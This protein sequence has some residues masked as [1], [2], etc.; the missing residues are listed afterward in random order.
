[1]EIPVPSISSLEED[2]QDT[3][4]LDPGLVTDELPQPYRMLDKVLNQTLDAVWDLITERQRIR[5]EEAKIIHPPLVEPAST[6][7]DFA[8]LST[9][10]HSGDGRYVFV[11]YESA[12]LVAYDAGSLDRITEWKND[13]MDICIEHMHTVVIG[14]NVHLLATIDDM[15]FAR[16]LLF[17][18]E[19][20]Y[21]ISLLNEQPE[22]GAKSNAS[23]FDLS[24]NGD[25]CGLVLE[26][27]RSM[28]ID[29]YKIPRDSWLREIESSQK[30]LLKKQQASET[31]LP[32]NSLES[33]SQVP[34]EAPEIKF[35]PISLVL[36]VKPPAQLF[37][38][39]FS[40]H[41]EAVE[42]AGIANTIGNGTSHLF[43]DDHLYKR[44]ALFKN[45]YKEELQGYNPD[46][47]KFTSPNWHY[48]YQARLQTEST[49]STSLVEDTPV[50]VCIW[51]KNHYLAQTY[52]LLSKPTKDVEL[53]PDLVWPMCGNISS[54]TVSDCTNII[55]F[56]LVNGF[57]TVID[58]HLCLPRATV[59]VGEQTPVA[60]INILNSSLFTSEITGNTPPIYCSLTLENGSV[61]LLDCTK[62][63]CSAVISSKDENIRNFYVQHLAEFP[64]V[65]LYSAPNGKT[66][67]YDAITGKI[68]CE[69]AVTESLEDPIRR[70]YLSADDSILYVKN[71]DES[72]QSFS[73]RD[74]AL[75]D[76]FHGE[77]N[78][79]PSFVV[80]ETIDERCQRFLTQRITQQRVRSEQLQASWDRMSKELTILLSMKKP[81]SAI[82][83][84]SS[85]LS[86]WH[87]AT[88]SIISHQQALS[89]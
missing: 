74:V 5:E 70:F 1:M 76:N 55:A 31:A 81:K 65:F 3:F 42:K 20:F 18:N 62:N 63:A 71:D 61:L 51:W 8:K 75:L 45:V 79:P 29:M 54:S 28:W 80:K 41:Q 15:G 72:V 33:P 35:S 34:I 87:K 89:R 2:D 16:L 37:G 19:T 64:R 48:L 30:E 12:E 85:T 13:Q 6:V 56:G 17:A 10:S 7:D 53:K 68:L 78:E 69:L 25:F 88:Y 73:F 40:N 9:V 60:Q 38:N 77:T 57:V 47:E 4:L 23:K 32:E 49:S 14:P 66:S 26:C 46:V 36:K 39:Y 58:R 50:S 52:P 44:R 82:S 67:L 11:A 24:K 27:D 43:S 22:G 21:F 83:Q 84:Q 59:G 86:K